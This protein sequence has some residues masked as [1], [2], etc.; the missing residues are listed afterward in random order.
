MH[1]NPKKS[2]WQNN[3]V[4]DKVTG[5]IYAILNQAGRAVIAKVNLETGQLGIPI[6]LE[7]KYVDKLIVHDNALY[8][9]YRP[10]ESNQKKFLYKQVLPIFSGGSSTA[11]N[12]KR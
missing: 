1:L 11:Q 10:Y 3:L 9:I 12:S 6:K 7:F 2:G 8:Y 4:Q 5:E